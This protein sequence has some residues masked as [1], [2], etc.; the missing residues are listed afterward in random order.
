[1]GQN[2]HIMD[3]DNLDNAHGMRSFKLWRPILKGFE[4]GRV[5]R[6]RN[7]PCKGDAEF[8]LLSPEHWPANA[9]AEDTHRSQELSGD[10]KGKASGYTH[11]LHVEL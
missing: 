6:A 11:I 10:G 5:L 3:K 4:F 8:G 9:G 2:D 7:K 1:M